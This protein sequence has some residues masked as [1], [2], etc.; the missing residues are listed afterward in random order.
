MDD[1]RPGC[2]TGRASFGISPAD[3]AMVARRW[4]ADGRTLFLVADRPDRIDRLFPGLEPVG[5]VVAIN[6][7][8][9]RKTIRVRPHDLVT[10]KYR[11][12]VAEAPITAG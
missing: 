2:A 9:L 4:R 5:S 8:L 11:F 12:V 7:R 10:E 3:L 1:P 6:T